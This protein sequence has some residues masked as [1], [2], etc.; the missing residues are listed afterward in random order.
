VRVQLGRAFGCL[1]SIPALCLVAFALTTAETLADAAAQA[2]LPAL[3]DVADLEQANTR[4]SVAASLSVQ[5][6]GPPLG[7]LLFAVGRAVPFLA[8]A[9]SF[10]ARRCCCGPCHH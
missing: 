5:F 8:D 6:A 1:A 3:V 4:L 10:A 2:L 7:G 9:V